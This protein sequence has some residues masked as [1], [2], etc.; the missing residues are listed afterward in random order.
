[1]Q[2]STPK[3]ERLIQGN[4]SR[5]YPGSFLFT[6]VKS[7]AKY[8]QF[9]PRNPV[10]YFINRI[11]KSGSVCNYI[12]TILVLNIFYFLVGKGFNTD[13]LPETTVFFICGLCRAAHLYSKI[14]FRKF[15]IE[16]IVCK[17]N[18]RLSGYFSFV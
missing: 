17:Y 1:M 14:A 13:R 8:Q 10:I 7:L 11:K 2:S 6:V 5:K 9:L 18:N 12:N 3:L 4:G 16:L 15:F